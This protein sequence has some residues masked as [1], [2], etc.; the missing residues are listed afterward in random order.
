[1]KILLDECVPFKLKSK[2][3]SH[4]V[5]SVKMMAWAGIKNGEL[6][7][8][9]DSQFDIFITIDKNLSYQQNLNRIRMAIVLISVSNNK[10]NTIL[11][12]SD[13]LNRLISDME[14]SKFYII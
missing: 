9:A 1:M 12:K 2:L 5:Y 4:R 3:A 7:T 8:L 10:L 6:I 14:P 11:E 13:S